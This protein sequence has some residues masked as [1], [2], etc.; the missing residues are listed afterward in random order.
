LKKERNEVFVGFFVIIGL[1]LLTVVVFFVS[2]VYLFRSG[3]SLNVMYDYVSILDVGAPVRMAGVRVGEVS[4]VSLFSSEVDNK[5][6]VNVGLFIKKDVKVKDHYL[7]TIQGTHILSEPHIEISPQLGEGAYLN[8]GDVI[9]GVVP[10]AVETL[11]THANEIAVELQGI[12]EIVHG[13]LSNEEAGRAAKEMLIH[14]SQLTKSLNTIMSGSEGDMIGAIAGL[15]ET[16]HALASIM[17]NIEKGEGTAGKLLMN[18][19]LYQ[20]M[21]AFVKEIKTHPWRLMKKD[22]EKRGK[23]LGII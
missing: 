3:Y 19:E 6:R 10:V 18:D 23:F 16:T 8:D 22:G 15:N 2:G 9:E 1:I 12:L 14:W 7:F 20:E 17:K 5:T 21:R 11:L 4:Q 13:A